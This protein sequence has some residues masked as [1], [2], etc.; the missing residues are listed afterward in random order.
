MH[1][2]FL[3]FT[4]QNTQIQAAIQEKS[5][6]FFNSENYILGPE[7]TAFEEAYA[8]F[9]NTSYCVGV[10]NGLDALI[11]SLETIGIKPG[12]E[13]IVPANTYIATWLAVSQV[14]AVPIPVEPEETTSNLDPTRIEAA[15]TS[16]TKAILPV[17]LYGQPCNM[18]AI[19]AI[20]EQQGLFI[21]EDN[22]QAHGARWQEQL[23]G[24]FGQIN[25]TSFYPT[26]N[27]G[28]LGDAGAIT[29]NNAD[30][31]KQAR[32]RRNYGSEIKNYNELVGR[33]SRL[34]ELQATYLNVK[35]PYLNS[36]NADRRKM[37]DYYLANL[38]QVSEITLPSILPEA[39]AVFHLFVIHTQHRDELQQFLKKHQV[40]T[41]V[42]YPVPPYLQKAYG[43]LGYKAG[44]FPITEKL[45][46]T[47]LSLP[48]WPGM[49][50]EKLSY[51]CEKI[52]QFFRHYN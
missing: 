7:V 27:L 28:A 12:D 50:E 19:Q 49:S 22:A 42:H 1:V 10:G 36:W 48:V 30:Y 3:S 16:K 51:V 6:H 5:N 8:A 38:N 15:I 2:P 21:V 46:Q 31:A 26:K 39:E 13:V 14:G 52:K 45:A 37:A 20:A 34:D 25:A 18:T 11:I 29:T 44:A 23:T 33:N 47:C 35:L 32:L 41:A 9:N 43:F 40:E 17:H 24:S 4:F